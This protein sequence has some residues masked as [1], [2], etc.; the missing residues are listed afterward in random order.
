MKALPVV[1]LLLLLPTVCSAQD[2]KKI[3]IA[4]VHS[5]TDQVGQSVFLYLKE[6]IRASHGF[7][8]VNFE[9]SPKEPRIVISLTTSGDESG[10][11]TEMSVALIF[12]NARI[13]GENRILRAPVYI[14]HFGMHCGA[15]MIDLCAN[16]LLVRSDMML[17]EFQDSWPDLWDD[18]VN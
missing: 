10:S 15:K 7:H 1:L 11:V 8:L 3:P 9:Q 4:A 16:G 2:A 6:A 17:S 18:L 13:I 5:G 14:D 12:W